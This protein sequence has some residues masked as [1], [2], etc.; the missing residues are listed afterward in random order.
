[1]KALILSGGTGVRL[2]PFTYTGAKQLLPVANK[3][4][5]FYIIEKI[6]DAGIDDIGIVVGD[7]FQEIESTVGN[8]DLWGV[9]IT[10]IYQFRPLGLADAVRTAVDFLKSEDFI[11]VLGDNLFHMELSD[12][13]KDFCTKAVNAMIALHISE[14][15]SQYGVAVVGRERVIR[16]VEK[17][18]DPPSNLIITGIYVF[19]SSIFDAIAKTVP[20]KRGEL[21][22]TDAMQVLIDTGGEVGYCLTEGWW[23]D[24]GSLEDLLEANRLVIDDIGDNCLDIEKP[25]NYS[26]ILDG[27]IKAGEHVV[28]T[29]SIL[30]GPIVLGNNISV[31]DCRLGPYTTVGD[32][33]VLSKCEIRD[34]ILLESVAISDQDKMITSSII[35]KNTKIGPRDEHKTMT[36]CVGSDSKI[37]L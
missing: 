35:G 36:F 30:E 11:M 14:N 5:L 4:I 31:T 12:V 25:E 32:N 26:S 21:E 18:K 6:A 33:A 8:G 37:I 10:Y 28:I 34:S 3:P 1:M 27:M 29:N 24:T 9:N 7:T 22:I 15:P 17:P 19:D 13:I 23:K 20:S 2:R 16:L